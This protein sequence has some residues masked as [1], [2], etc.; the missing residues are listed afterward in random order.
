[1]FTITTVITGWQKFK[2][3]LAAVYLVLIHIALGY[4]AF[5]LYLKN[6]IYVRPPDVAVAD[7]APETPVPTPL[8]APSIIE[9]QPSPEVQ[10]PPAAEPGPSPA[11]PAQTSPQTDDLDLVIP[12]VGIKRNQLTD[13]FTSSRSEGRVHDA[14]DIMAP[15]GAA[16]VAA[17]DGEIVK[18]FDSQ[19]GGI[20]IY[21]LSR[22][23]KYFYYYAHLLKRAEN[24]QE[25]QFVARGTVIGYVGD[26]G[27]AGAG[28]YHLHFAISQVVDPKRYWDGIPINPYPILQ[29]AR[30]IY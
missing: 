4:F 23:G 10:N 29:R 21:Q 25:H 8:V 27:N 6:K 5:E 30:E 24:I 28:N 9:E 3:A 11:A 14:I 22:D 13:T 1:M 12:V 19:R 26:T 20:T 16:V 15:G 7:P 2:R 18:F 17:G